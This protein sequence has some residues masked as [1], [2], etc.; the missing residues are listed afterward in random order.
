MLAVF[1]ANGLLQLHRQ[2]ASFFFIQEP[3]NLNPLPL[4]GNTQPT[5]VP[6]DGGAL[7]IYARPDARAF[8]VFLWRIPPLVNTDGIR[9]YG[10]NLAYLAA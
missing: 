8:P 6:G 3:A 9:I 7:Q 5:R 10:N 4:E 1:P 2:R